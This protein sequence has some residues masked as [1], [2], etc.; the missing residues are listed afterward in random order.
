MS[1]T[2]VAVAVVLL[3]VFGTGTV[4]ADPKKFRPSPGPQGKVEVVFPLVTG[5]KLTFASAEFAGNWTTTLTVVGTLVQYVP[6]NDIANWFSKGGLR[7][8]ADG[9]YIVGETLADLDQPPPAPARAIAFPIKKG[10]VG[11]VPGM[12]AT[13]YTVGARESVKT[14]AGS[15]NAWHITLTDTA[16]QIGHV[17]IAPGVGVVKIKLPSGRVDELIKIEAPAK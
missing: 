14:G 4:G 11:K 13:T 15:F 1:F 3:L 5:T 16:H 8:E 10:G 9:I 7:V 12:L 2:R 6:H 17:W